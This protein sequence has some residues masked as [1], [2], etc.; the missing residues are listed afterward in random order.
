MSVL[1]VPIIELS[2]KIFNSD[3]FEFDTYFSITPSYQKRCLHATILTR[4]TLGVI[5]KE[6]MLIHDI[7]IH[8]IAGACKLAIGAIKGLWAIPSALVGQEPDYQIHTK[9]GVVHLGFAFLYV[10]DFLASPTNIN[11]AYPQHLMTKARDAFAKF[12][13]T[14]N[15]KV[16]TQYILDPN[17]KRV[18]ETQEE[19]AKMTRGKI[20]KQ[21]EIIQK[22]EELLQKTQKELEASLSSDFISDED[23]KEICEEARREANEKVKNKR[24][25][26]KKKPV[27]NSSTSFSNE[28]APD[29]FGYRLTYD[30]EDDTDD[31]I[32]SWV[33]NKEAILSKIHEIE[34]TNSKQSTT[35]K[36]SNK[37]RSIPTGSIPTDSSFYR[38]RKYDEDRKKRA[39]MKKLLITTK[40]EGTC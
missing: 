34:S 4:F 33:E 21:Q 13:Q 12:L 30:T 3:T 22:Q 27:I 16:H 14:P 36:E 32:P 40:K 5:G 19:E 2:Q 31:N 18:L 20:Q 25:A 9:Q 39:P 8:L 29:T 7:A 24:S 35:P 1:I 38:R 15:K 10:A 17:I 6:A 37:N 23:F 11:D 28:L 26:N